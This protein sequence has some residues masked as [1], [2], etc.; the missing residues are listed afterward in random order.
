MR[1]RVI[2]ATLAAVTLVAAAAPARGYDNQ[3]THRYITRQAAE[4]L[5]AAYPGQYD[6]LL[7]YLDD[8][9]AGAELEDDPL[10][11]GD[12]DPTTLRVMRHFFRPTDGVGLTM[13]GRQ[14]PSSYEWAIVPSEGNVWGWDDGLAHWRRGE[15]ADAY[16]ALGQVVH[17]IQD[18][19][20]PAHTHLDI[21]GPPDGDD[22]EDYCKT[23]ITDEFT[24]VLPLPPAGAPIPLFASPYDAWM[25][26]ASASYHRNLYPGD[27]SDTTAAQ[28]VIA[29]MFPALEFHWFFEE[30]R[31]GDPAVG[32]LGADFLEEQPGWFYF[33]NAEHPAAIDRVGLDGGDLAQNDT[34]APMVALFARDLIPLAVLASAGVMKLYL[35]QAQALPIDPPAGDDEPAPPAED[36]E[37]APGCAVTP[38]ARGPFALL[39][40]AFAVALSKR[41]K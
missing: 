41:R 32:S 13:V 18:A 22:Y 23:Q 12:D 35:D 28:G 5:V 36:L 9:A 27:L 17:L 25:A 16:R 7:E 30:W 31:I 1:K 24:S 38:G 26:T 6:E 4:R 37:D 3:R 40:L 10:L 11:D 15:K 8:V 14:F 2:Q 29:L 33:K 20:V 21:H 19:T 34:G 39:V